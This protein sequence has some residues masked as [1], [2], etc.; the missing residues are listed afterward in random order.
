MPGLQ[1]GVQKKGGAEQ[2]HDAMQTGRRH[3]S[4]ERG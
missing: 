4:T 3:K 2:N 1:M